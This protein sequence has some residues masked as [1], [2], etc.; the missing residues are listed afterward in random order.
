MVPP[1]PARERGDEACASPQA[2]RSVEPRPPLPGPLPQ[3]EREPE[4]TAAQPVT[5][6]LAALRLSHSSHQSPCCPCPCPW[7]SLRWAGAYL[8]QDNLGPQLRHEL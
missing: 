2:R 8:L 7:Q 4:M 1:S 5:A 6:T 3:G